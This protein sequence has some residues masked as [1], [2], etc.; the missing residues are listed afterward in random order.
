MGL[1]PDAVETNPAFADGDWSFE[2]D[3][4]KFD[5]LKNLVKVNWL[6]AFSPRVPAPNEGDYEELGGVRM[7][8]HFVEAPGDGATVT[9]H[10]VECGPTSSDKPT[11]VFLHGLPE[12]WYMWHYQLSHFASDYH[13]VAID[14]KGYGLSEKE[15]GDYR[16]EG[17]ADQLAA[18]FNVLGL[19]SVVIVSH[20]R[21]AV[22]ADYLVANHPDLVSLYIRGQQ[23][24]YHF[25]PDLAPQQHLFADPKKSGVLGKPW[26]IVPFTYTAL[27]ERRI[28]M[29]DFVR[30]KREFSYPGIREAVPRYFNSST[31]VKEWRDRRTRLM[32]GW[33]CPVLILQGEHDKRQPKKNY[34]GLD[35]YF[36]DLEVEFIDAGHF[37]VFEN[38][39][40]TTRAIESF[41]DR[42]LRQ[43]AKPRLAVGG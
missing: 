30:T 27:T 18:L 24:L 3:F 36:D 29:A 35:A 7:R 16:Q 25:H 22:I 10:L 37:F 2:E 19:E 1:K 12:S 8:H 21:G 33:T 20:D 31:F 4:S 40:A 41:I 32:A 43:S 38:P 9:W 5:L 15:P 17:V 42:K 23:H 28:P 34:E 26:L 14:L 6:D 13:C 11:L 39:Q